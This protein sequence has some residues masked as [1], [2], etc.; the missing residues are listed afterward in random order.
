LELAQM[1]VAPS[2][3]LTARVWVNRVWQHHFGAGLVRTPSDF[4][5]RAEAPSHPE[6]LDWLAAEFIRQGWSTKALHR[7]ILLSSTYQQ[8]AQ[9]SADL[10]V[11]D[12]AVQRDP[13]NRLLWRANL[14]RLAFEEFRDTILASSCQLDPRIGGR[15]AEL[16]AGDGTANRRRT[17]YGLVD[18]QFLPAVLR[19]FDFANPDL[20]IPQRSETIV[21]QQALFGLNHPWI[22]EHARAL[23]AQTASGTPV[24]AEER[25]RRLYQAALQ[26]DPTA[27][28]SQRALAFIRLPLQD[29][30][31]A[32]NAHSTAW[33][34]GYGEWN[35]ATQRLKSFEH[36]PHFNGS[37]WQGGPKWPDANLGWLQLTAQGGHPGNDLQH[38]AVRRWVAPVSGTFAVSSTVTHD[39]AAGDGIRCWITGPNGLLAQAAVHNRQQSL[40]VAA[41]ALQQGES[42]DF[43]VDRHAD[44]DSEQHR[45][46]PTIRQIDAASTSGSAELARSWDAERDFAG[47]PPVRLNRWEQLAQ[48]LLLSNE[49]M[50]V[51]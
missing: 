36:L 20:H 49:L 37:A 30:A 51:D 26:R 18:R 16:F 9:G 14:R 23:V 12:R 3:P 43:V 7:L 42:L 6:L 25:L 21:P 32:V 47:P 28:E 29:E 19:A 41:V 17:L 13:D 40:E 27:A 15:A 31:I 8:S 4:G 10:A 5:L 46:A 2:N 22:A 48:V 34:Y 44:L 33:Q 50:F 38:A 1:I 11:R 35:D 39:V 45:W 24:D